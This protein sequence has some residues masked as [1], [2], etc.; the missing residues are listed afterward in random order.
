[1]CVY[2]RDAL[3]RHLDVPRP[4]AL[5][6]SSAAHAACFVCDYLLERRPFMDWEPVPAGT[7]PPAALTARGADHD[8][9]FAAGDSIEVALGSSLWI[10]NV[11]G[12]R[13][14][15]QR[16]HFRLF[17]VPGRHHPVYDG[18]DLHGAGRDG[19]G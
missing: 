11:V 6:F 13:T 4:C 9:D 18:N 17:R 16:L 5:P 2:V 12:G 10:R 3:P 8:L 1:M 15:H 7:L 14:A 19:S